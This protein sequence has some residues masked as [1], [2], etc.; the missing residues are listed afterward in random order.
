MKKMFEQ[1]Q[2]IKAIQIYEHPHPAKQP[3]RGKPT[4]A[5]NKQAKHRVNGQKRTTLKVQNS[6]GAKERDQHDLGT[7][8][9][10]RALRQT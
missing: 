4:Q 7:H 2:D 3:T 6:E 8:T 9:A 5:G 10:H 1:E